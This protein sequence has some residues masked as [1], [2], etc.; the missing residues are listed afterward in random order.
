LHGI[1]D[2]VG[3]VHGTDGDIALIIAG[4]G[5]GTVLHIMVDTTTTTGE[6][7]ITITTGLTGIETTI[8]MEEEPQ[9]VL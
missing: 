7:I 1:G 4:D 6:E 8:V 9:Q 3:T 5:D 2:T